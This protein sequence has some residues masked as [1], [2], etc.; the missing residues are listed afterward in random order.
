MGKSMEDEDIYL[1]TRNARR[2]LKKLKR[3]RRS[4]AVNDSKMFYAE[5]ERLKN[6]LKDICSNL[7]SKLENS[8]ESLS[9]GSIL[10]RLER[11][12]NMSLDL[13]AL[14]AFP[15]DNFPYDVDS[16]IKNATKH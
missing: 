10:R 2:L 16:I 15:G 13:Q 11:I 6:I 1:Q 8:A 3:V 14:Y 12:R 5:G 4:F 9:K 7:A